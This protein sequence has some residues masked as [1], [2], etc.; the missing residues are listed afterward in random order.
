[1]NIIQ[2][3]NARFEAVTPKLQPLILLLLRLYVASVFLK[4]GIQK[5]AHWDS[6]LFLFEYEYHVPLLS[7]KWAAI[8]GTAAEIV[9]PLLLIIGLLTRYT[10]LALFVFNV[11]AVW[12]YPALSKGEWGLVTVFNWLPIGIA[13]PTK[14]FEDHVVWGLMLLAIFTFGA[15]KISLDTL[16]FKKNE[17]SFPAQAYK[18]VT[19]T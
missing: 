6:T 19:S 2:T 5:V 13:F 15:G 10:A 18:S 1:M 12:S 16:F 4:S 3:F 9:L 8:L 14:G 17:T 7:A 11:I